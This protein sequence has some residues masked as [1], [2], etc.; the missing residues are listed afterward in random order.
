MVKDVVV[1]AWV[2]MTDEHPQ[3]ERQAR[4][5]WRARQRQRGRAERAARERLRAEML[6]GRT[7]DARRTGLPRDCAA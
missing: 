7:R 3:E 4:T 6:R 2:T 5:Y 1:L